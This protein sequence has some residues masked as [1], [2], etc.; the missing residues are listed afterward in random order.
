MMPASPMLR[1]LPWLL[2]LAGLLAPGRAG[3]ADDSVLFSATVPPNVLILADNSGSM[4]H[5]V[6]HPDFDREDSSSWGCHAFNP[7]GTAF[8]SGDVTAQFC[9]NTRTVY[10]DPALSGDT[11]WS[12]AYLNWYF[13]LDENDPAD[14]AILDELDETDNGQVSDCLGGGSFSKYRRSRITALK[15][16]IR[17]VICNVNAAGTVRFGLAQFRRTSDG[18]PEG[19]FVRVP[20]DDWS[21]SHDADLED[22]IDDLAPEAWTPL[23]ETLFQMYTYFMSRDSND[24]PVGA[25]GSTEFPAYRYGTNT[26]SSGGGDL[27]SNPPASP[28][29]CHCQRNF[30]IVITDGEPTMDDFDTDGSSGSTDDGFD[31]FADLIGDYAT[32]D[33][34]PAGGISP[35]GNDEEGCA[36]DDTPECAYYLDDIAKFM[37]D[38][39]FRPDLQGDQL[40]DTYTIGFTTTSVANGLLSSTA[41]LGNGLFRS[42]NNAEELADAIIAALTDIIE[43]SQAFTSATVPAT[44]TSQGGNFYSSFF[45]PS[46]KD[47]FWEG[48]IRNFTIDAQGKILDKQGVCALDD[49][50]GNCLEGTFLP[51]A[52]PHWDAADAMPAPGARNLEVGLSGAKADLTASIL[53][54]AELTVS[55]PPPLP[56]PNSDA[57]DAE[58]LADEIVDYIRGC[59]F[60]TRLGDDCQE[61]QRTSGLPR[62]LGDVFHSNP[63]VVGPPNTAINEPSYSAFARSRTGADGQPLAH[64]DR[65]LVAGANDGFLHGFNAGVFQSGAYTRGTGAEVFGFM[66]WWVRE[67]IKNLPIDLGNRDYYFVDGSPAV[68][69]VWLYS[70]PASAD[71][72]DVNSAKASD[73]SEWSTVAIGGLRQGGP[74]YYALDITDPSATDYPEY[75]WEFPAEG[76]GS[77]FGDPGHVYLDYLGE[78]WS[79]PVIARVKVT[80]PG[81]SGA[82]GEYERWVAIFGGGYHPSGDPN[83][84][85]YDASGDAGTSRKG[86]GVF[87]V[88]IATGRVLGAQVYHHDTTLSNG[89]P[90]MRYS[91]ASSP[92][93]VDLDFDGFADAV[94]IGDLGGNL[95]KWVIHPVGEDTVNPVSG[96][97]DFSGDKSQEPHWEFGKIF[98]AP[99]ATIG[100]NEYFKSFFLAPS[101]TFFRGELWLAVGSGERAAPTF[102][103]ADPADDAENNRFYGI[104]DTNMFGLVDADPMT[105][106]REPIRQADLPDITDLEGCVSPGV[107]GYQLVAREGE[108]FITNVQIVSFFVLAGS[109]IPQTASGT[110]AGCDAGGT[111]NLYVFKIYCGEGFFPQNTG[112]DERRMTL[113]E[114]VPTDPRLS[115]GEENQIYIM[116]SENELKNPPPLPIPSA[117]QGILYWR[118]RRQ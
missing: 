16:V 6:W 19:G 58:E 30:V 41:Q 1:R 89:N 49:P 32:G 78:S 102:A 53:G 37:Q 54:A 45:I 99:S 81:V 76:D 44:R 88:D 103:G 86:R 14:A 109:F 8:I 71:L 64:R 15:Q 74:V 94:Y 9:G 51:G 111:A 50:S 61:R 35:S 40:I 65:I 79:D 62:T 92:A 67:N 59:A 66:P 52:E 85:S 60:G 18:D 70:N 29:D 113:G 68:A 104:K 47:P 46:S 101:L 96:G 12:G 72:T 114:G 34:E 48:H 55:F 97:T 43:K 80:A 27:T 13:G 110:C 11:R 42:S 73:G 116:T 118:E 77:H 17:E 112:A 28:V 20:I 115:L 3:L 100:G 7:D 90:E 36:G 87:I 24:I 4:A 63:V 108:K 26:G 56:Y 95:W 22:A 57:G 98:E 106:P 91:L 2:L 105:A 107:L 84:T 39:D 5:I 69:D 75:L 10:H 83:S 23:G 33:F 21:S 31:D 117:E 25:D 93:V 82:T 38:V